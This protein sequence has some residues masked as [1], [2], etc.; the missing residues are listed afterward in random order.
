MSWSPEIS[1]RLGCRKYFGGY[2]VLQRIAVLIDEITCQCFTASYLEGIRI[3]GV[4][5]G[6][7]EE[8]PIA[9]VIVKRRSLENF[10]T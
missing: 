6:A 8:I 1:A 7:D 9:I 2:A 3:V 5:A 4:E 10:F